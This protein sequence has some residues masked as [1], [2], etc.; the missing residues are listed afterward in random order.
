MLGQIIVGIATKNK[1]GTFG[2]IKITVAAKNNNTRQP[3]TLR[4][5]NMATT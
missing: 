2:Q 4:H 5:Y 3:F 1:F